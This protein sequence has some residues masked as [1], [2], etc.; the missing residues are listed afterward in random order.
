M[1]PKCSAHQ[2]IIK[3]FSWTYFFLH[4][5]HEIGSQPGTCVQVCCDFRSPK[6][7]FPPKGTISSLEK[8]IELFSC[9]SFPIPQHVTCK[10]TTKINVC[11]MLQRKQ[12]LDKYNKYNTHPNGILDLRWLDSSH[13]SNR[14]FQICSETKSTKEKVDICFNLLATLV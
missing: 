4:M 10:L 14:N 8:M 6:R 9:R 3:L 1:D 7:Y 11:R 13:Q 5:M 12:Y 2:N